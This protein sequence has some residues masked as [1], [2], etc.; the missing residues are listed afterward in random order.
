MVAISDWASFSRQRTLTSDENGLVW[1]LNGMVPEL[2]TFSLTQQDGARSGDDF[3]QLWT[4]PDWSRS[5]RSLQHGS[6]SATPKSSGSVSHMKVYPRVPP[7]EQRTT[8]THRVSR[9]SCRHHTGDSNPA[10]GDLDRT[11]WLTRHATQ[12]LRKRDHGRSGLEGHS[13]WWVRMESRAS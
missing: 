4:R 8:K 11:G 10:A 12:S 9:F 6:G 2:P 1:L 3:R 13:K 5:I 7:N